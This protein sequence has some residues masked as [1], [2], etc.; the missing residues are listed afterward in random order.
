[1]PANTPNRGYT[2][3]L[4]AD[5]V[6]I[7][8]DLEEF[9]TDVDNDVEL[10]LAPIFQQTRVMGDMRSTVIQTFQT[11]QTLP[12]RFD[13][14]MRDTDDMVD[15]VNSP[16][17]LTVNTAGF[18]VFH[19]SVSVPDTNWSN[20]VLR[21]MFNSTTEVYVCDQEFRSGAQ[22]RFHITASWMYPM[23]VGDTMSVT[24]QHNSTG[25]LW[26]STREL[27]GWRMST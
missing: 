5:P 14:E 22:S 26:V 18:Y 7:P 27:A 21:M 11:G 6:N 19:V 13:V 2:Y 12:L 17:L 16:T 8:G 15:V 3:P 24:L 9:A 23:T 1:M 4:P 20:L 25:P 10:N